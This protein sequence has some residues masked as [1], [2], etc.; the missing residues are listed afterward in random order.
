M[1]ND[2]DR[3]LVVGAKYALNDYLKH[4][5]YICQA[6]RF[7][8]PA[9]RI[10]FYSDKQVYPYVPFILGEVDDVLLTPEAIEAR[11]DIE[12]D[13]REKL[14]KIAK[15]LTS[16]KNLSWAQRG[17]NVKVLF[18]SDASSSDTIKLLK[19]I[20]N[21]E[22]RASRGRVPPFV[23]AQTYGSL[24]DLLKATSTSELNRE[25]TWREYKYPI[26]SQ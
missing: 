20:P 14:S 1:L 12:S 6:G 5:A 25:K 15:T 10:A 23:Q 16:A 7:F 8:R 18:L 9:R 26:L 17:Y 19:P 4:S 24:S 3:V 22:A 11:T 13:K 2:E 21:I